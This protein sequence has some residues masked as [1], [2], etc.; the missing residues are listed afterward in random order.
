[1]QE[2]FDLA[3]LARATNAW[4]ERGHERFVRAEGQDRLL[5]SDGELDLA[6][7]AR[8]TRQGDDGRRR[9]NVDVVPREVV[10]PELSAVGQVREDWQLHVAIRIAAL[11][12]VPA[13]DVGARDD[14]D[15]NSALP[16]RAREG[17]AHR[18]HHPPP[19]PVGRFTQR[20]AS[21][22]PSG[23][24]TSSN[25]SE[26]EPITPIV[27]LAGGTMSAI[28]THDATRSA[29]TTRARPRPGRSRPARS[30][31]T[32][33]GRTPR[34]WRSRAAP[35]RRSR[36]LRWC[37]A[38]G[39]ASRTPSRTRSTHRARSRDKTTPTRAAARVRWR[40]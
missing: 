32:T 8:P 13:V 16:R 2:R 35:W 11:C 5:V 34:R 31:S 19:A 7:G 4:M 20:L 3:D 18:R 36:G 22:L 25:S 15:A 12:F 27:T 6:R 40:A 30:S 26:P 21:S 28:V 38:S 14:P 24:A 9:Q 17:A 39:A 1:F 29:S 10:L 33:P 23:L 37:P